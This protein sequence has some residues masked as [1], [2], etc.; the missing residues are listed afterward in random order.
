MLMGEAPGSTRRKIFKIVRTDGGGFFGLTEWEGLPLDQFQGRFVKL[1][2]PK[3]PTAD[4]IEVAKV[5]LSM[6]VL[7][8][9]K[10]REL[11][12]GGSRRL[13]SA[14]KNG[15]C[16]FHRPGQPLSYPSLED[17][18]GCRTKRQSWIIVVG[19]LPSW[20]GWHVARG[21]I[22]ILAGIWCKPLPEPT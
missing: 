1:L 17:M 20:M 4:I 21:S 12:V 6:K 2:P 8:E 15:R 9:Q 13:F 14:A 19:L 3:Q 18:R 10:L 11:H 7:N 5:M 22:W 16:G